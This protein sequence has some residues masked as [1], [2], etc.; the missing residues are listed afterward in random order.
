MKFFNNVVSG[1]KLKKSCWGGLRPAQTFPAYA[2][3]LPF[4]RATRMRIDHIP[5]KQKLALYGGYSNLFNK[6]G[7]SNRVGSLEEAV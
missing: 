1:E 2:R 5:S 3:G 7:G 4:P 6:R